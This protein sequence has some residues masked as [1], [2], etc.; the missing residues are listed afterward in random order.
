MAIEPEPKVARTVPV[1]LAL[2]SVAL[3]LAGT[4]AWQLPTASARSTRATQVTTLRAEFAAL[5]A[6]VGSERDQI[7][8]VSVAVTAQQAVVAK[9]GER[10]RAQASLIAGLKKQLAALKA[11]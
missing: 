3:L 6:Q 1:R 11:R 10:S 8:S 7:G 2:V 9:L 5:T 4:L